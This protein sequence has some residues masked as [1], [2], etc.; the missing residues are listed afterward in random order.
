MA[1]MKAA[2]QAK[3]KT[4]ELLKGVPGIDGIGI[5]WDDDGQPCVRVNVD[6]EE[7]TSRWEIPATVD[8]VPVKVEI[9]RQAR[10]E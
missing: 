5:T 3:E 8:G 7:E 2:L 4:K 9:V 1:T 10:L 6:I